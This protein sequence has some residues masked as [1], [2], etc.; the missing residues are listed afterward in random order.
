MIVSLIAALAIDRV[1]GME[2]AIPWHLSADLAWFK[3]N[4]RDKSIIM[5]RRTFESIGKPLAGRHNIVLSSQPG[6][7]DLITWA[8]TPAQALAIV[9][10]R[11][12][13]MVIGGAK[14][15]ELFFPHAT[16]LY[17][18]HID[19][20]VHGDTWFPDY[21]PDEWRPAFSESHEA[22]ENNIHRY[23]FEILERRGRAVRLSI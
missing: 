9:N 6:D 14:V 22:D 7:N 1:I 10:D 23:R 17:L 8:A 12:E 13:V 21:D 16:R 20:E 4:T 15:Y 11:D 5:G 18:T 19:A 2:N 3:H